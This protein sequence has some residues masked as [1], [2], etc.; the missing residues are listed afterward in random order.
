MTMQITKNSVVSF[1]YTLN[2]A[3]GKLLRQE[4]AFGWTLE[5]CSAEEALDSVRADAADKNRMETED[6]GAPH[7]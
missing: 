1:H 2:D 5:A 4:T 6:R 7:P 3:D